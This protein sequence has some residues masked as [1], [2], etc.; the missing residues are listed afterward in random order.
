MNCLDLTLPTLIISIITGI[1]VGLLYGYI[2]VQ[3]LIKTQQ[4]SNVIQPYARRM[5]TSVLLFFGR[6]FI[7]LLL[8][9]LLVFK[10]KV[11]IVAWCIFFGLSFWTYIITKTK[12][13]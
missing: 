10:L 9:L 4:H 7:L 12:A 5:L 13:Q 3:Q 2:F 8:L 11:N 1:V 6:Y